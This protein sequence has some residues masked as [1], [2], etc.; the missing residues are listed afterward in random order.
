MNRLKGGKEMF[1]YEEMDFKG[2]MTDHGDALDDPNV[3]YALA[4]FSRDGKG[5]E[6]S[7]EKYCS[8]L[9][10]ALKAGYDVKLEEILPYAEKGIADAQNMVGTMYKFGMNVEQDYGSAAE[11]FE[12]AARNGHAK[13]QNN[14]GGLYENGQGVSKSV[15]SAL[16]WY[17]LSAEN[18]DKRGRENTER[19]SK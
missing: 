5:C 15:Q 1:Q 9:M 13:A 18:G 2:L 7:E 6:K 12:K 17:R 3:L 16:Y 4:Q 14:L 11:W 19:L 8:Y 10:K